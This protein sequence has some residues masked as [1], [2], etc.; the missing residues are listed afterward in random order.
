[1]DSLIDRLPTEIYNYILFL[2]CGPSD[3]DFYCKKKTLNEQI[4]Q[5]FYSHYLVYTYSYYKTPEL[6]MNYDDYY[7]VRRIP[8][9]VS[10][11]DY[12]EDDNRNYD[13]DYCTEDDSDVSD[14]WSR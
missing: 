10:Y 8:R 13:T 12:Y 11:D 2:S 9:P 5:Q 3:L 1:M 7:F 4:L 6:K 14:V